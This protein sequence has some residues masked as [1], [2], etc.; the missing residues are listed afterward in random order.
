M[1]SRIVTF[2]TLLS[3]AS[4]RVGT[5]TRTGTS[6]LDT[7]THDACPP[8]H[9]PAVPLG[10]PKGC[11]LT[12]TDNPYTGADGFTVPGYHD[13][14]NSSH[15][16]ELV[17]PV[18]DSFL[19][20]G[21]QYIVGTDLTRE[22]AEDAQL[23]LGPCANN[24]IYEE[25]IAK[26]LS[27]G[28]VAYDDSHLTIQNHTYDTTVEGGH[29]SSVPCSENPGSTSMIGFQFTSPMGLVT[30]AVQASLQPSAQTA[31]VCPHGCRGTFGRPGEYRRHMGKH[32]NPTFFCTQRGCLKSFYRKD[33]LKD[34]LRQG[35]GIV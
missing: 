16:N 3:Y 5:S 7:T 13:S 8:N 29:G 26:E 33:K 15:P 1:L 19:Y 30:P 35:H 25:I 27:L 23:L 28:T 34:H 24:D 11:Y 14:N 17:D 31:P 12:Q 18:G 9:S 20:P 4:S 6:A 2:T 22:F 10:L 32:A 21:P